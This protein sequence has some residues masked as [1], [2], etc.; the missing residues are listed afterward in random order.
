[1]IVDDNED[2]L[3]SL[4]LLLES[5]YSIC[6]AR[7]GV[8][9]LTEM[10]RGFHPDLILL[11]FKMPEMDGPALLAELKQRGEKIPALVISAIPEA[12]EMAR[13]LGLPE[14]L[15]RPFTYERLRERIERLLHDSGG[16]Q[17]IKGLD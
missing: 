14:V 8:E 12:A 13:E 16:S 9:A 15:Q 6:L 7:N 3:E 1:M 5:Y 2:V 11:D 10:D 4:K 17:A